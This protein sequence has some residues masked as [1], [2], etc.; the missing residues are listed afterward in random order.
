MADLPPFP[1]DEGTLSLLAAAMDP[2]THGDPDAVK[3]SVWPF[4]EM[5][6]QMAGS[7]LEAVEEVHEGVKVMRDPRYTEHCVIAA[8]IAEVRRLRAVADG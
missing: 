4:L 3:S 5:L 6:S 1:V 7:D 8:L 2:W